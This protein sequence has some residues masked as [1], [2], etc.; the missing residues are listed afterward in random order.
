M[1]EVQGFDDVEAGGQRPTRP[2][3]TP[4]QK[5]A[6]RQAI[7]LLLVGGLLL[8][9]FVFAAAYYGGWFAKPKATSTAGSCPTTAVVIKVQPSQVQVNVYNASKR[10][11]LAKKVSG[12]MKAQGYVTGKVANDPLNANVTTPAQIRYGAKGKAAAQLVASEVPGA[13]MV[14]DKR[15]DAT[16]DLVLGASYVK[17]GDPPSATA[18]SNPSCHPSTTPTGT[19]TTPAKPTASKT[20]KA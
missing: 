5:R 12:E 13:K 8:V 19:H 3:L 9:S 11:G 6:R 17:L 2:P 4:A 1:S 7:T 18:S 14:L 10:N 16:V 15:K 20:K